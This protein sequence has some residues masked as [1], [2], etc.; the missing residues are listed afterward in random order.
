MARRRPPTRIIPFLEWRR[1]GFQP[2]QIGRLHLIAQIDA[3]MHHMMHDPEYPSVLLS[4]QTILLDDYLDLN[5]QAA[6][7]I[8]QLVRDARFEVGPWYVLPDLRLVSPEAII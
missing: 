2:Y 3:L 7:A 8:A 1:E 5:P 4:G 6:D